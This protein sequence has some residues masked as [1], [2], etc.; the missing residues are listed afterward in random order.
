MKSQVHHTVWCNIA[1]EL[2][3]QEIW[4]GELLFEV[5][6]EM[7]LFCE[8][9]VD[10]SA[11]YSILRQ[12]FK[13][14]PDSRKCSPF[15]SPDM[16]LVHNEDT[17]KLFKLLQHCQERVAAIALST[18]SPTDTTDPSNSPKAPARQERPHQLSPTTQSTQVTPQHLHPGQVPLRKV[19]DGK[20]PLITKDTSPAQQAMNWSLLLP[21]P[22]ASPLPTSSRYSVWACTECVHSYQLSSERKYS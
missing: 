14:C 19:S 18:A 11:M 15:T 13:Q 9:S 5:L 3:G 6:F 16:K 4:K 7:F 17:S 2:P 21:S 8:V 22:P 12:P 10:N 1:G 20:G